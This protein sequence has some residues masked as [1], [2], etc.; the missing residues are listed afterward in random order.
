MSWLTKFERMPCVQAHRT[1]WQPEKGYFNPWDRRGDAN[2][3]H[4]QH[5]VY[6]RTYKPLL[7][8]PTDIQQQLLKAIIIKPVQE[9]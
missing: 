6:Q 8:Q 7:S 3:M 1:A 2:T 4:N 5:I 9:T